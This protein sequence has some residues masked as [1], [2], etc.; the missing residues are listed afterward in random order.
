MIYPNAPIEVFIDLARTV[1]VTKIELRNDLNG[2][3]IID[4]MS[5]ESFTAFAKRGGIEVMTINAL[6]KFNLPHREVDAAHE[7]DEL[8]ALA[9][10]IGCPAIVLCPNNET[11]DSRDATQA[12]E[13][14]CIS[15]EKFRPQFE[16][17]GLTGL[18]EPLGFPESSLRS[19][20]AAARVI[21]ET[22]ADCYKI[23]YDTFHHFLGPDT[24]DSIEE[25]L[26]VSLVGIVHASGVADGVVARRDAPDEEL[27]DKHRGLIDD[28]DLIG[29]IEQLA[30]LDRIGYLGA[31]SLEPFSPD[32]ATLDPKALKRAIESCIEFLE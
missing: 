7:L 1:G 8:I 31:V 5:P 23:V 30:L 32:L 4:D 2:R 25:A 15:L 17:N 9:L 28:T 24:A 11:D 16:K 19:V 21:V 29:N 27:L 6:Q 22:G 12:L 10:Q 13:D 26:D 18:I 20:H 14:T 3:G